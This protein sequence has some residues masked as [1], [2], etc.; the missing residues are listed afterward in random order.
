VSWYRER[1]IIMKKHMGSKLLAFCL[2]LAVLVRPAPC[3]AETQPFVEV[4]LGSQLSIRVDGKAVDKVE[5]VD[6]HIM[7]PA[8]LISQVAGGQVNGD[9]L[10]MKI[11]AK[12]KTIVITAA[13]HSA[14][15]NG[16]AVNLDK[17]PLVIG[18]QL[19]VPLTFVVETLGAIIR[20]REDIIPSPIGPILN[21][22][23]KWALAT[24]DL[25]KEANHMFLDRIGGANTDFENTKI[26]I[27]ILKEQW[28]IYNKA[29]ALRVIK[30]LKE[31]GHRTEFNEIAAFI[32]KANEKQYQKYLKTS[33]RPDQVQLVKANYA[34]TGAKSLM[35]WDYCRIV[36]VSEQC[37]LAGYL[38]EDEMWTAIM[39]AAQ[40]LQSTFSSWEDMGNDFLMGVSYWS[41]GRYDDMF[42][43]AQQR[44][45]SRPDSPW[46][47]YKWNMPL[48]GYS[49]DTERWRYVPKYL[50]G[51]ATFGWANG[52]VYSGEWK[53]GRFNGYG[54]YSYSNGT[55][56]TGMFKDGEFGDRG[57]MKLGNGDKY[58]GSFKNS[59]P[60]GKGIYKWADGSCY[61]GYFTGGL[62]NGRGTMVYSNG[63]TEKGMW[64]DDEHVGP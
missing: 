28:G 46:L 45:L 48:K 55:I 50:N 51:W 8:S 19:M 37:Y 22:Q 64:K 54:N 10:V 16:D 6:G 43:A 5:V 14:M 44:L 4:L 40:T 7:V 41:G 12:N 39:P 21:D 25:I 56:F 47:L 42:N 49:P 26:L 53:N 59:Q 3:Y 62:R 27:S 17:A 63:R 36:S 15:I 58:T 11:T 32:A 31:E 1:R 34:K 30:W 20:Y 18:N 35:A 60:N 33:H 57:I 23:Q 52:E 24:S 9:N 38:T 13:S 2:L 29:D 61:D